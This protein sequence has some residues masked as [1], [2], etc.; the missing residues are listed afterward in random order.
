MS[1]NLNKV[2]EN[3][4]PVAILD[5]FHPDKIVK[6][7]KRDG[8]TEE[9]VCRE[10]VSGEAYW[11]WDQQFSDLLRRTTAANEADKKLKEGGFEGVM[12][13]RPTSTEWGQCEV[14]II[15]QSCY[16]NNMLVERA[17]V[18][19]WGEKKRAA[20]FEACLEANGFS[21]TKDKTKKELEKNS[22]TEPP[23]GGGS[24]SAPESVAV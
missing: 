8:V 7:R 19:G 14:E 9:F 18:I 13:P 24:K 15:C 5:E 23:S 2:E 4:Q 21:D 6:F 20:L 3:S 12:T 1:V 17:E 11:K 22:E 10:S 16:R